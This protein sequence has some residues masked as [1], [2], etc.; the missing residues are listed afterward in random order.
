MSVITE[1]EAMLNRAIALVAQVMGKDRTFLSSPKALEVLTNGEREQ[2]IT[3]QSMQGDLAYSGILATPQ[4]PDD[5]Q[6][7]ADTKDDKGR[8]LR[9]NSNRL[10]KL[11]SGIVINATAATM[12]AGTRVDV[13]TAASKQ[14]LEEELAVATLLYNVIGRQKPGENVSALPALLDEDKIQID[15]KYIVEKFGQKVLGHIK[16]IRTAIDKLDGGKDL[17]DVQHEYASAA[18]AIQAVRVREAAKIVSVD[19]IERLHPEAKTA[20]LTENNLGPT[21][22][23]KELLDRETTK[24][25]KALS[26]G[27]IAAEI[28]KPVEKTLVPAIEAYQIN[29]QIEKQKLWG[30]PEEGRGTAYAHF[31]LGLPINQY[32]TDE[33]RLNALDIYK[34]LLLIARYHQDEIRKDG[35]SILSH[36]MDV[37]GFGSRTLDDNLRTRVSLVL[38]MHDLVEDGGRDVGN[39][40]ANLK[41]IEEI[42]GPKTAL[43]IAEMTDDIS[44]NVYVLRAIAANKATPGEH[45]FSEQLAGVIEQQGLTS[46][47]SQAELNE[48]ISRILASSGF[49]L[50][51]AGPKLADVVS[52]IQKNLEEPQQNLGYWQGSG[53]RIGWIVED[54]SKGYVAKELYASVATDTLAFFASSSPDKYGRTLISGH[55]AGELNEGLLTVLQ[56]SKESFDKYTIQ[57]LTILA[58]EFK[59]KEAQRQELV[60]KFIDKTDGA[61]QRLKEFLDTNLLAENL[62]D[63][64]KDMTTLN[65]RTPQGP[66]RSYD[67]LMK[68]REQFLMRETYRESLLALAGLSEN[69]RAAEK[70]RGTMAEPDFT[71]KSY[72]DVVVHYDRQMDKEPRLTPETVVSIG[73]NTVTVSPEKGGA[74]RVV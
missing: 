58:D 24:L 51:T 64:P 2:A 13:E 33:D 8:P 69:Q 5:F 72:L 43:T 9:F 35:S 23:A 4:H 70:I 1:T 57:N 65:K 61:E 41:K 45:S 11:S 37:E 38:L 6:I 7:K 47:L 50:T 60:T 16:G 59:L 40:D 17:A 27:N 54:K 66:E 36:V 34:A 12:L 10:A 19:L 18:T 73:K 25:K 20:F 21:N 48:R 49:S 3:Y 74:N 67:N 53:A 32:K 26:T 52:T 31:N 15:E 71:S 29:P 56:H 68:L 28:R 42:F 14:G 22:P 46:N 39:K 55:N 30:R 63:G 44:K 62:V